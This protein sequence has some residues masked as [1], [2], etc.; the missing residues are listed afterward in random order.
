MSK[1]ES[2]LQKQ[3]EIK[4]K[5]IKNIRE[6][7]TTIFGNFTRKFNNTK[8]TKTIWKRTKKMPKN[9][10]IKARIPS[11]QKVENYHNLLTQSCGQAEII[12]QHDTFFNTEKGRFKL[13]EFFGD[14]QKVFFWII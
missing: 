2:K 14:E 13:R 4:Q 12:H 8:P 10:E 3:E 6:N 11:K 7:S 5:L 9:I 1:R